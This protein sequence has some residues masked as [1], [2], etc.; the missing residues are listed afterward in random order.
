MPKKPPAMG[1]IIVDKILTNK[2]KYDALELTS[3]RMAKVGRA[4]CAGCT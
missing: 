2:S 1:S 3:G 4:A